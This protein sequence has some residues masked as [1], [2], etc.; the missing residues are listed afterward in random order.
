[1]A[2]CPEHL[3]W[4]QNP[5][6]TPVSE[7]CGVPPP[8]PPG[9]HDQWLSTLH[10]CAERPISGNP[11]FKLSAHFCIHLPNVWLTFWVIITVL[12][13]KAQ[14]LIF[15]KVELHVHRQEN[16]W[17]NPALFKHFFF[18]L[19]P[20]VEEPGLELRTEVS[21]ETINN[22]QCSMHTFSFDICI[23]SWKQS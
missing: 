5:K 7:T 16:L 20:S 3:K 17:L 6:F 1:M 19:K 18:G 8:L 15:C 22:A 4:D 9:Y 11:G 2:F 21:R 13:V 10:I 23:L 12:G 14:Q